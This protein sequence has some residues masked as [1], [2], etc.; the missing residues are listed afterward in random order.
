MPAGKS[1]ITTDVD[2]ERDGKQVGFLRLPYSPHRSAYG[3]I[4]IP[5]VCIKRGDGPRVLLVAG[6]HGDEYEGQVALMKL[7]R[8]IDASQVRGRVIILPAANF[9]AV[10]AGRRT[11]PLDDGGEGNLNRSFP[12]DPDGSPTQMIAHYIESVLLPISDYVFDLHSGGSS[13]MLLPCALMKKSDDDARTARTIELMKVFGAPLSYVE[14]T[15]NDRTMAAAAR[16][17][18]TIHMGTELGGGGTVSPEA[19]AVGET[20]L[21]RLL[22]HVGALALDAPD[23]DAPGTRLVAVGAADYYVHSP[24]DGLFE[25]LVDL[26]DEVEKGQPAGAVHFPETPWRDPSLA[27]FARSGLVICKRVPGRTERGDCLFHLATEYAG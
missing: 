12:G 6:N 22:R 10:K 15:E 11:S 14:L 9:P 7:C 13:L 17:C 19:L 25:P 18:G 23:E 8:E 5:I 2:L 1:R 24:D 4:P 26:G 27:Y 20:G 21:R 16:R 3:W